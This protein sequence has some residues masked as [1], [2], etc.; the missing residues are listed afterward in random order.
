MFESEQIAVY[1]FIA[2]SYVR[3][4]FNDAAKCNRFELNYAAQSLGQLAENRLFF[5]WWF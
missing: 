5:L 4:G 1:I 2:I 3:H